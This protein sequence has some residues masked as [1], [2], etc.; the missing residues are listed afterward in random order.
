ML[1]PV[2][3]VDSL[4]DEIEEAW[5]VTLDRAWTRL[6]GGEESA[7]FRC[8]EI[9]VRA[10]PTWRRDDELEWTNRV[11]LVGGGEVGEVVQPLITRAGT[12]VVRIDDR[13]VTLWPFVEGE[14]GDDR[15]LEQREQAAGLLARLHRALG[16]VPWPPRPPTGGAPA[17]TPDLDDRDLDTWLVNFDRDHPKVHALHG[18]FYGGNVIVDRGRIVGLIDWD[19]ALVGP[20]EREL[21]WAAFEWGDCLDSLDLGPALAFVD[22]YREAGGPA[23]RI[24]EHD[25]RQLVRQRLRLE[26]AW[27]RGR[28]VLVDDDDDYEARRIEAF[29][30]LRVP[31]RS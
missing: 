9:V 16:R 5:G 14:R 21:A 24:G 17:P 1:V 11:A 10:G 20:P 26:S 22:A 3:L 27:E 15:D 23:R 25:L 29:H 30:G 31:S 7:A 4:I 8:G 18:D 12:T 28:G 13:P 6:P 2:R 19:E